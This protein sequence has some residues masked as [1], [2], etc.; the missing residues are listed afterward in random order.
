MCLYAGIWPRRSQSLDGDL[1]RHPPVRVGRIS[2]QV[3]PS[4][5]SGRQRM[6]VR[7]KFL[8]PRRGSHHEERVSVRILER[9]GT[10]GGVT[11]SGDGGLPHLCSQTAHFPAGRCSL[12]NDSSQSAGGFPRA[13]VVAVEIKT[14][15]LAGR[16]LN[17]ERILTFVLFA[18]ISLS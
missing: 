5:R 8:V 17:F 12:H 7:W 15:R 2:W 11:T 16:H 18:S 6:R 4:A 13:E 14:G 10:G 1:L 3:R 9:G